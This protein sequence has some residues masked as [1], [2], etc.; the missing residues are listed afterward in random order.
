MV[1]ISGDANFS[2]ELNDL[3]YVH[4]ITIILLHSRQASDALKE[5]ANTVI[6]FDSFLDDVDMHTV[7]QVLYNICDK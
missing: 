3:R 6:D 2:P 7:K 1:L 4:N 5:F